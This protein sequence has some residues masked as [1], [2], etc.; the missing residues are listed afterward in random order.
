MCLGGSPCHVWWTFDCEQSR[1]EM[2][3][4]EEEECSNAVAVCIMMYVC[5]CVVYCGLPTH[6]LVGEVAAEHQIVVRV[7]RLQHTHTHTHTHKH[8]NERAY[9]GF[10]GTA[11]RRT[12][13]CCSHQ[14]ANGHARVYEQ[15]A[16]QR[17]KHQLHHTQI[18]ETSANERSLSLCKVLYTHRHEHH[19]VVIAMQKIGRLEDYLHTAQHTCPFPPSIHPIGTHCTP[20]FQSDSRSW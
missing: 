20:F 5:I 4:V 1:A 12:D 6:G 14:P 7:H 10:T 13:G 15:Q 17:G 11:D 8:T 2:E 9:I 3:A 16:E 18:S 19:G